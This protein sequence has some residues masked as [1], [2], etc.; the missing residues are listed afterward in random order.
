M[1]VFELPKLSLR[2]RTILGRVE[3]LIRLRWVA[4]AGLTL[5]VLVVEEILPVR[6]TTAS[7]VVMLAVVALLAAY[8]LEL[9]RRAG[10]IRR[11]AVRQ[12]DEAYKATRKLAHFQII[13]D[14]VCLAII[15]NFSGGLINPLCMFMIFHVA[16]AG[17]LLPRV[18]AFGVALLSSLLLIAMG[19]ANAWWPA[20]RAPLEGFP[21][22][23]LDPPLTH[24]WFY[25][26]AVC[27]SMTCTFLLIAYFTSGVSEQLRLAYRDLAQANAALQQRDAA[28]TRLMR[29]LAHQLRS[30]LAAITSL[31]HVFGKSAQDRSGQAGEELLRRIVHRCSAMMETVDDLLR[32]TKIQ[33]GLDVGQA[34]KPVDVNEVIGET[35][36]LYEAQAREKGLS[37]QV[38]LPQCP[39]L[40]H[41]SERDLH[42]LVSNLVSNAIKYTNAPGHVAVTGRVQDRMYHLEV[43]DTG[44][45]IPE[46]DQ[47]F[48]FEEFFRAGN[49]RES[50][51]HSSGLGLN[52]VKA[53]VTQLQGQIDFDSRLNEGTRFRVSL[54][55]EPPKPAGSTVEQ[56]P[57]DVP[58]QKE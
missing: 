48:L 8:N 46:E 9:Q 16:I 37:W 43:A 52:I 56:L 30:P 31:I 11:W 26:F 40:M 7:I 19:V 13:A 55:L 10:R 2:E 33:Q 29:V 53:I 20:I 12:P 45:G 34:D 25:I 54:P 24:N 57:A 41:V 4:V 47:P 42:D 15:L 49:A 27:A 32:L 1:G 28:K 44:I 51:A 6:F 39:L 5:T 23:G 36:K 22:E 50:E 14:L 21:L 35:L 3:W 17:I 18:E 58:D 38:R